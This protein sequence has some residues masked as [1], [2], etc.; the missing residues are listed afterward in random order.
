MDSIH[1]LEARVVTKTLTGGSG[2][3][4]IRVLPNEF[5]LK[6]VVITVDLKRKSSGR[7]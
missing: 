7:T 1:C 5:L 3:S 4:Y 2:Y 6:S